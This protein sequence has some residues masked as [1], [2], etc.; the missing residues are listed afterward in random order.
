MSDKNLVSLDDD[1]LEGVSGGNLQTETVT[2]TFYVVQKGDTLAQIATNL[3][4][5]MADILKMNPG[6]KNP[7]KIEVGQKILISKKV[8]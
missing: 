1:E 2:Q 8:H 3:G 6:I 5:K 7:D 4:L